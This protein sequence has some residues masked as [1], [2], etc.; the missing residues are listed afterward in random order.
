MK[1]LVYL[2]IITKNLKNSLKIKLQS[3]FIKKRYNL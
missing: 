1:N 3:I 2:S